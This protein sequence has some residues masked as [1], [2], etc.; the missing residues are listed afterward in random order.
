[1][2]FATEGAVRKRLRNCWP[3]NG[4]IAEPLDS[5]RRKAEF[6]RANRE[7]ALYAARRD[8][9]MTPSQCLEAADGLTRFA[10]ELAA[11]ARVSR[12]ADVGRT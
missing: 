6:E 5:P 4:G 11:A 12:Q 10:F 1:M 9:A 3:Y 2:I 7:D 8:M